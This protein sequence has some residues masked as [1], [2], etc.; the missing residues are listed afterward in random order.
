[1]VREIRY[2]VWTGL[3]GTNSFMVSVHTPHQSTKPH[4][5][6]YE[7]YYYNTA[8]SSIIVSVAQSCHRPHQSWPL[9]ILLSCTDTSIL[10]SHPPSGFS[11]PLPQTRVSVHCSYPVTPTHFHSWLAPHHHW[12]TKLLYFP[13][14][15][16]LRI[17]TPFSIIYQWLDC[18]TRIIH[19][20]AYLSFK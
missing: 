16:H 14:H 8:S 10:T 5:I 2:I 12:D 4:I 1:M 11:L 18:P 7:L 17:P 19:N 6:L 13:F 3:T 15:F 20:P 9:C